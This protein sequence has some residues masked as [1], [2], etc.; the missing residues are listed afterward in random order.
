MRKLRAML[1]ASALTAMLAA[2]GNGPPPSVLPSGGGGGGTTAATGGE[3]VTPAPDAGAATVKT[4]DDLKFAPASVTVKV[5]DT[6][7]WMNSGSVLHNITFAG[8]QA[9][10]T[11][12]TFNAGDKYAVK[13]TAAGKYPYKCTIHPGM[14]GD[15]TVS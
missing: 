4:G 8:A 9:G 6:V 3:V 2:C 10:L 1:A 14:V 7:V 15:V 13:F 5:G 11:A 12:A